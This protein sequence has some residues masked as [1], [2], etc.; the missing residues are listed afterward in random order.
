M[1]WKNNTFS[2]DEENSAWICRCI[3]INLSDIIQAVEKKGVRCI[4]EL[5]DYTG[6]TE[7]C[8]TC[9]N[10]VNFYLKEILARYDFL[11][12][13]RDTNANQKFLPFVE[14]IK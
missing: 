1:E 13:N 5:A 6:V 4:D 7:G 12:K 3:G 11:R 2:K 9:V 10:E 14:N 8:G